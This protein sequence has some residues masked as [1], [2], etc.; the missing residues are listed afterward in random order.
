MKPGV[1]TSEF[2]CLMVLVILYVLKAKWIPDLSQE[3]FW[4]L[5]AWI[6]LRQG[7]KGINLV[8]ESKNGK[9][10]PPVTP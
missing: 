8:M 6:G 9:V 1:K 3:V 5:L 10:V 2:I 4:A 7:E